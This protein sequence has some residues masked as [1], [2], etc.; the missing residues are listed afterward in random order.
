[1]R[2]SQVRV[3]Q[4]A[5]TVGELRQKLRKADVGAVLERQMVLEERLV[6][7]VEG[8]VLP[9]LAFLHPQ[10]IAARRFRRGEAHVLDLMCW[11]YRRLHAFAS[12][13][14]SNHGIA[15]VVTSRK[16][17][18]STVWAAPSTRGRAPARSWATRRNITVARWKFPEGAAPSTDARTSVA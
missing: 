10:L 2:D 5:V 13:R 14:T 9:V 3:R 18:R 6:R 11:T 16:A 12:G 1:I 15:P 4:V 8:E 17:V 7:D